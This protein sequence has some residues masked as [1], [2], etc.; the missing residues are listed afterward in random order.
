M[1]LQN[2]GFLFRK[3]KALQLTLL[4]TLSKGTM[5]FIKVNFTALQT[6]ERHVAALNPSNVLKRGYSI[7]LLNGKALKSFAEAQKNDSLK[8]ILYDGSIISNVTSTQNTDKP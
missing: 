3:E 2:S 6:F 5:Q 7:T 1:L 8:T 4:S